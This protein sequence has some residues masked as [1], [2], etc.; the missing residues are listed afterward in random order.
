LVNEAADKYFIGNVQL[1]R[2]LEALETSLEKNA[3]I[4][5]PTGSELVSVIGEMAGILPLEK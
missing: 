1:L 2:K 5:I 3:R 4:V